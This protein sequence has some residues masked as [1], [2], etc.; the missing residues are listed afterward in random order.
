[1]PKQRIY[2]KISEFI[3]Y[4][5]V[6]KNLSEKT[7]LAY[8]NDLRSFHKF[9]QGKKNKTIT[10][11]ISYLID[12]KHKSTTIKRHLATISQYYKYIYR[13]NRSGNPM[14]NFEIKLKSEKTLPRTI[15]TNEVKKIFDTLYKIKFSDKKA[16][17]L[18]HSITIPS[19]WNSQLT[20]LKEAYHKVKV[21]WLVVALTK[22]SR[23]KDIYL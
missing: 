19:I 23:H 8:R 16:P 11:Y 1:M 15:T 17:L 22:W 5:R 10:D 6:T 7:L 2:T 18:R 9:F 20:L 21:E 14:L 3:D 13:G 4:C 12:T